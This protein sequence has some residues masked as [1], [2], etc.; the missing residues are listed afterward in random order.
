MWTHENS[1]Y[2]L[3]PLHEKNPFWIGEW[4]IIIEALVILLSLCTLF[5]WL[6]QIQAHR[7]NILEQE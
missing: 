5:L 4:S 3:F 7:K 6:R 1:P 2:V